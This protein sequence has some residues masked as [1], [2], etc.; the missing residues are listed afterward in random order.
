[1]R[2]FPSNKIKDLASE[3]EDWCQQNESV[4][5][6]KSKYFVDT[7]SVIFNKDDL[8]IPV[9]I[10]K[11]PTS[12]TRLNPEAYV[13]K[14]VGL[15][16]IHHLR[17]EHGQMQMSKAMK[18]KRIH[19]KFQDLD[20]H[21]LI[22]LLQEMVVPSVRASYNMYLEIADDALACIMAI[23]GLFLFDLLCC[24]GIKKED[25]LYSRFLSHVMD[26]SGRRLAKDRTLREVMML[27]NQIPFSVLRTILFIESS[28]FEMVSEVLPKVLVGFCQ[29]VSPFDIVA[30]YPSYKTLN[31][32]H[33]LDLLYHLIML[34]ASPGNNLREEKKELQSLIELFEKVNKIQV[35]KTDISISTE[36][37]NKNK[38]LWAMPGE[39]ACELLMPSVSSIAISSKLSEQSFNMLQNLKTKPSFQEPRSYIKPGVKFVPAHIKSIKFDSKSI[40]FHLP[41][42]KLSGNSEVII[43]NLVAYEALRYYETEPL[44]LTKYVEI[45]SH[46]I[47]TYE[48]VKV[49][50]DNG[51]IEMDQSISEK[52]VAK[53]LSG[54][55]KS[56]Q[57]TNTESINKDIEGVKSYYNGL[58]KVSARRFIKK[59][60]WI[61]GQWCKI[62]A[63]V[64]LLLLAGFQAFCSVYECSRLSFD[65]SYSQLSQQG[66]GVVS[67][68]SSE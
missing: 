50:K 1:M 17:P 8:D 4:M 36:E 41:S 23:D 45:M 63:V 46:L 55:T 14:L 18:A 62:L 22:E 35:P 12:L 13:P 34:N 28:K 20:F 26:Y 52:Q 51:I 29:Y 38:T 40:S 10:F 47:R 54:M 56:I 61:A 3:N 27:E 9:S 30:D 66:L 24:Y 44:V 39:S 21:K 31:H 67:M 65:S 57:S 6:T 2:D 5:A 32:A 16:A 64:L 19:Q 11:V 33:L 37:E 48:D 15:G 68:R 49:L 60:R 25:Y 58:W 53:V 42:I 43:K 7:I 59:G